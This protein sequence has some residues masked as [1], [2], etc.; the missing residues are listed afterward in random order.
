M[1][2]L[3]LLTLMIGI[4]FISTGC[5]TFKDAKTDPEARARLVTQFK[6]IAFNGVAGLLD[7]EPKATNYVRA[8]G[9]V[10]NFALNDKVYDY[11]EIVKIAEVEIQEFA[12]P[13]YRAVARIVLT[14]YHTAIAPDVA[15]TI[16]DDVLAHELLIAARQAIEMAL[17]QHGGG[18]L[19]IPSSMAA[20]RQ[21][22]Y[23]HQM[24]LEDINLIWISDKPLI[25][26]PQDGTYVS[27]E[28]SI[29]RRRQVA[30]N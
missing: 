21:I 20:D 12:K 10:I 17:S 11:N 15:D 8:V 24:K 7:I 26:C 18:S 6:T 25:R 29:K 14:A 23:I 19:V 30:A 9:A 27:G 13:K 16:R 3:L 4:T 5:K 1:K 22:T 2:K 28:K